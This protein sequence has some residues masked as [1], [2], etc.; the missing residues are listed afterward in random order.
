MVIDH[1]AACLLQ[2]TRGADGR[3]LKYSLPMGVTVYEICRGIGRTALP[4]FCFLLVEGFLLT[5]NR[6]RYLTRILVTGCVAQPFFGAVIWGDIKAARPNTLFT[7]AIGLATIWAMEEIRKG[8]RYAAEQG[9]P[10]HRAVLTAA[11]EAV[12]WLAAGAGAGLAWVLRT[13]YRWGGVLCIVLLYYFHGFREMA[14]TAE[15]ICL[16]LYSETEL[17]SIGGVLLTWLY[18][19]QRGRQHRYTFYFFYPLHLMAILLV[20]RILIGTW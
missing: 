3:A 8:F 14:L 11:G 16:S 19:G 10:R 18:S 7:L 12:T 5:G 15:W 17:L 13:D 6:V 4:V 1:L 2:V 20:K 9:A